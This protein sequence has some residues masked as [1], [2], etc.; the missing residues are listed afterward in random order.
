MYINK[1]LFLLKFIDKEQKELQYPKELSN[2]RKH[3]GY[4]DINNKDISNNAIEN[5]DIHF[6]CLLN[7]V[8]L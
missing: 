8:F 5:R 2:H 3:M 6:E 7:D 4:V 1:F